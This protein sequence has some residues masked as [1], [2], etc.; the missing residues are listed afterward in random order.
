MLNPDFR[1]MLRAFSEAGVDY[2]LVGAYALATHGYV[3]ATGDIDLWVR[4]DA[5]NAARVLDAL[6]RFGAPTAAL[7]PGDFERPDVVLQIGVA[8]RRIDVLTSIDGVEFGDAWDARREV[9]VDGLQVPVIGR[10]HLIRN[11]EATGRP[12]DR[13]DVDA[14]RSI[15]EAGEDRPLG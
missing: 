10:E 13:S 8:P 7:R 6:G 2:L 12:R 9:E 15:R 5:V 11:K 4:P 14:L 1:D 3:R